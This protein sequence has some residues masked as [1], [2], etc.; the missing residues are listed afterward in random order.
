LCLR[1][2]LD[3]YR[4]SWKMITAHFILVISAITELSSIVSSLVNAPIL[5][6]DLLRPEETICAIT[7][8]L[9]P[10][11]GFRN[12]VDRNLVQVFAM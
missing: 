2:I 6:I 1:G 5:I 7:L 3:F 4:S 8:L 10:L 9:S 12:P 11:V